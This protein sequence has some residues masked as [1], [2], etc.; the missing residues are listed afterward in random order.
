MS[1]S[2]SA[3]AGL[4]RGKAHADDALGCIS[5]ASRSACAGHA[6]D[7]A[8]AGDADLGYRDILCGALLGWTAHKHRNRLLSACV[9]AACCIVIRDA[10]DRG[11]VCECETICDDTLQSS[12]LA[13]SQKRRGKGQ[14]GGGAGGTKVQK[15]SSLVVF[16]TYLFNAKSL[17]HGLAQIVMGLINPWQPL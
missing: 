1:W 6:G 12:E 7:E 17:W 9:H 8:S 10:L 14:R 15:Y 4:A 5:C 13:N 11:H 16:W 3:C 2:T